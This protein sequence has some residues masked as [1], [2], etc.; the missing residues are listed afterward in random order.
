[1]TLTMVLV[2]LLALVAPA[3]A[4]PGRLDKDGCH[5]VQKAWRSADGILVKK[6]TRHCH[7]PVGELKLDGK[8][9]LMNSDLGGMRRDAPAAPKGGGLK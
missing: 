7:R 2:V 6:G 4:H 8:E 9:Q 1:M 3:G 5:V